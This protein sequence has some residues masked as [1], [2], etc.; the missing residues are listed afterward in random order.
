M[1]NLLYRLQNWVRDAAQLKHNCI[2]YY[3]NEKIFACRGSLQ[4]EEHIK[5]MYDTVS[6][7]KKECDQEHILKSLH[8][9]ETSCWK[10]F[11]NSFKIANE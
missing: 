8:P 9:E 10:K 5:R 2:V 7:I 3:R 4:A 1:N 6:Q 11:R